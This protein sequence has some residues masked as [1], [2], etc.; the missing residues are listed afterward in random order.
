MHYVAPVGAKN[1]YI[2]RALAVVTPF[3]PPSQADNRLVA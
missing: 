1:A 2:A 3:L